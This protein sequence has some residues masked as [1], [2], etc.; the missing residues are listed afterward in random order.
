MNEQSSMDVVRLSGDL[1]ISR[2]AELTDA[3]ARAGAGRAVLIDLSDVPYADSTVIAELLRFRNEAQ[4]NGRRIALLI[5]NAQFARIL[6]Y[7]GLTAAFQV[8]DERGAALTYL[9]GTDPM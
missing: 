9:A 5:G 4:E 1:D 6:Q 7:A 2:R 8:F 3:L